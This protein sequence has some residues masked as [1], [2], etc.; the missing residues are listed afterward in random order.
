MPGT[1]IVPFSVRHLWLFEPRKEHPLA[2][3]DRLRTWKLCTEYERAGP[4]FTMFCRGEIVACAGVA[5]LSPGVGTVWMLTSAL[6]EQHRLS[7]PRVI[8]RYLENIIKHFG[9]RRVQT[10]VPG[11]MHGAE[12]WIKFLGLHFEGTMCKAGAGGEDTH[13]Y[14]R[15]V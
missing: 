10:V 8:K 7:F 3:E 2:P 15:L 9:L 1:E 4:A 14:A 12:K 11:E 5:I 13:V 6:I